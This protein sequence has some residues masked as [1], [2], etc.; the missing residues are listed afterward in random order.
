M[1]FR[2]GQRVHF[3]GQPSEV[4][5]ITSRDGRSVVRIENGPDRI[6]MWVPE[7][8]LERHQVAGY[9]DTVF[10]DR[11]ADLIIVDDFLRDPDEV[12][13][14]ALAQNYVEAP[15]FYKGLRS[16]QRF[17]WPHLREEFSRL[18]NREVTEWLDH[19]ANGVFQQTSADD[20][21]VWHA[22]S[23]DFAAAI[24]L[25]P[26]APISSGTSFW[27][28][29]RSGCRRFPDHPREAQRFSSPQKIAEVGAAMAEPDN[30]V[31]QDNWE[32]VESAA[33]LYNRLVI[34]DAKLIHSA[35]SYEEFRPDGGA[36]PAR[37]VQLFFFG[38]GPRLS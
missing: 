8:I 24:Y 17:L 38:A 18:L 27:R 30:L 31:R 4:A 15:A 13:E 6:S 32:L 7:E 33:G 11:T 16:D 12:R 3:A 5:Q 22:D 2:V 21:L 14:I 19:N 26:D 34:W 1:E 36:A 10:D 20:P 25:T 35:T 29:R 9:A 28:D 37:L 23:Q